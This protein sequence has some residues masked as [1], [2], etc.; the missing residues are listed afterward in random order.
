MRFFHVTF[1]GSF[2]DDMAE[3]VVNSVVLGAT[4]FQGS[5]RVD[6]SSEK[7]SVMLEFSY[8]YI[9]TEY[10]LSSKMRTKKYM[11]YIYRTLFQLQ[12]AAS[13]TFQPTIGQQKV[14]NW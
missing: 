14:A 6:T 3:N 1:R 13:G 2:E 10:N 8:D 9:G 7:L 12:L 5:Q 4:L 11:N